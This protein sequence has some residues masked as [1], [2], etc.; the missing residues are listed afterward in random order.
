MALSDCSLPTSPLDASCELRRVGLTE[1]LSRLAPDPL[2]APIDV[3]SVGQRQRLALARMLCRDAEIYLLDEPDAN[4]DR[5]G[6]AMVA[7]LVRELG[8]EHLVV[9]AS[10]TSELLEVAHRIVELRA[11]AVVDHAVESAGERPRAAL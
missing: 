1:A 3:L 10:H 4:L 7:E 11:G 6:I 5:T 2:D 8:R 9:M